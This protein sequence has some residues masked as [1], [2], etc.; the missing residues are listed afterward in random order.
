MATGIVH[1]SEGGSAYAIAMAKPRGGK[2]LD[3]EMRERALRL[4]RD[5][6]A[7]E[8]GQAA[9]ANKLGISQGFLSELLGGGRGFGPKVLK[10]LAQYRPEIV[11]LI[12]GVEPA[13]DSSSADT[14]LDPRYSAREQAIR[15]LVD[16]GEGSEGEVREA[17]DAVAVALSSDEDLPALAWLDDIRLKLRQLRRGGPKVAPRQVT[18]DE[19]QADQDETTRRFED[20]LKGKK[21]R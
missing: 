10:G 19:A 6:I 18:P 16:G 14:H 17:A 11:S 15:M 9:A 20:A 12:M 13:P 8:G 1:Q 4:L 5:F 7:S 2:S 21:K 3:P